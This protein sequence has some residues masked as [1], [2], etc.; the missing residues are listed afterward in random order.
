MTI[1][2]DDKGDE[3]QVRSTTGGA[4][5]REIAIVVFGIWSLLFGPLLY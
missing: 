4:S 3:F 2:V 5:A 1:T